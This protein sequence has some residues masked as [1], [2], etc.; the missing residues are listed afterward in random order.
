MT[1]L[2]PNLQP[3]LVRPSETKGTYV[4][5]D[6]H[7]RVAAALGAG[8]EAMLVVVADMNAEEAD[9]IPV[10]M[11]NLRGELDLGLTADVVVAALQD[12]VDRG[13]ILTLSGFTDEELDALIR[14]TQP[15]TEDPLTPAMEPKEERPPNPFLLELT[16]ATRDDL[17]RVKRA[18]KRAAGKGGTLEDGL[19]RILA[20]A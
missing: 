6:G 1:V 15:E 20:G 3:P 17:G 5:V 7:H 10:G 8:H 12:G 2:G 13:A 16:F 11:G 18:L 14:A 4:I 19:L 9:L